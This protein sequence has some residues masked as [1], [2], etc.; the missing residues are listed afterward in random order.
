[1]RHE[2]LKE[3]DWMEW[4]DALSRWHVR[5]TVTVSVLSPEFG[6]ETAAIHRPLVGLSLDRRDRRPRRISI[7]T[8]S[9]GG[10]HVDRQVV[11]PVKISLAL[12]PDGVEAQLAIDAVDGTT[13]VVEFDRGRAGH[14]RED[15]EPAH[16]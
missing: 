16:G 7:V 14:G 6:V 8:E 12:H 5:D 2:T 11:E 10:G 15:E 1:M 9:G 13:T 3:A 4:L